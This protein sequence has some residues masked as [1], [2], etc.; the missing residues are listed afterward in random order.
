MPQKLIH[1][2]YLILLARLTSL[3]VHSCPLPCE[4]PL[5]AVEALKRM[6]EQNLK[7]SVQVGRQ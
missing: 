1:C 2:P 4:Q 3:L 6:R 5:R 7:P